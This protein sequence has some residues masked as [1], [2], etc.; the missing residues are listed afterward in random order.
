MRYGAA[1]VLVFEERMFHFILSCLP[2][3]SK[4]QPPRPQCRIA[5]HGSLL[6]FACNTVQVIQAVRLGD[7]DTSLMDIRKERPSTRYELKGTGYYF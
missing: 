2:S 1:I 3:R 6:H 5:L 7:G 4:L